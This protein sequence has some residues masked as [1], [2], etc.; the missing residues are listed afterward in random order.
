MVRLTL[1]LV[2][3]LKYGRFPDIAHSDKRGH[4]LGYELFGKACLIGVVHCAAG[5]SYFL[6]S[7]YHHGMT[8]PIEKFEQ[9]AAIIEAS[10]VV[11]QA[12]KEIVGEGV[13]HF[14]LA[15]IL[16]GAS[17]RAIQDVDGPVGV[18]AFARHALGVVNDIS[19]GTGY[20]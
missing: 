17:L 5:P 11:L 19:E 13:G 1:A 18:E 15:N 20:N 10:N 16:L 4:D 8:N 3:Q 12:A 9:D 6:L 2:C 7:G 14:T